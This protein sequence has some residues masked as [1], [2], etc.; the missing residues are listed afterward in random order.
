MNCLFRPQKW[1]QGGFGLNRF[2]YNTIPS[3]WLVDVSLVG[4]CTSD[5]LVGT[6]WSGLP[7]IKQP[8]FDV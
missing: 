7:E 3:V 5:G 1:S 2:H 4:F 6:M 8:N